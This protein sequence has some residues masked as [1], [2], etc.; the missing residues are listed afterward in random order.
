MT[1]KNNLDIQI[2]LLTF[3]AFKS[4][5][6]QPIS[7]SF[8]LQLDN[9][10]PLSNVKNKR[11]FSTHLAEI[12]RYDRFRNELTTELWRRAGEKSK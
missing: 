5:L 11:K 12:F 10:L 4:N 2:L 7:K 3:A 6:I 9:L 1:L 8:S